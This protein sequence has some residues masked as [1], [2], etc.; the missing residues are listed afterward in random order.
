MIVTLQDKSAMAG[1]YLFYIP[2]E[3][4]SYNALIISV[5]V[6]TLGEECIIEVKNIGGSGFYD[7]PPSGCANWLDYWEKETGKK[8]H[9]CSVSDCWRSRVYG[10]TIVGG[11]VKKVNSLDNHY[12]IVPICVGCNNRNDEFYVDDS[13]LVPCPSRRW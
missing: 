10:N 7:G 3:L 4:Y 1:F 9:C 8:A 5:F 6:L 12:Y 13:L 11:H 2:C